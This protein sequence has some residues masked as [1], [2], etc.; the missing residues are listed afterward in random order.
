[1]DTKTGYTSVREAD[2][3][4]KPLEAYGLPRLSQFSP[5]PTRLLPLID[6]ETDILFGFI[7]LARFALG[8]NFADDL[9]KET[10]DIK[11]ALALVSFDV[12]LHIPV[13]SNGDLK[14]ALRHLQPSQ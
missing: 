5:C 2:S 14:L 10:D 7:K 6:S 11:T 9:F 1:M 8:F 3:T 12:Q 13:G 4:A